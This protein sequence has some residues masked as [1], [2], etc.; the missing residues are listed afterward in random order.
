[1]NVFIAQ[2][3]NVTLNPDGTYSHTVSG[4]SGPLSVKDNP[5]F[6]FIY[7]YEDTDPRPVV[8]CA[9]DLQLGNGKPKK[10]GDATI[11]ATATV[12]GTVVWSPFWQRYDVYPRPAIPTP[13]TTPIAAA[14]TQCG[15]NQISNSNP[16]GDSSISRGNPLSRSVSSGQSSP[17]Y[18][19]ILT[20]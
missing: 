2:T 3:D 6:R 14:M 16:V 1:M 12:I 4:I 13:E 9:L 20:P 11:P 15:T 8:D 5:D 19:S 7:T 18:A 17:F 10:P